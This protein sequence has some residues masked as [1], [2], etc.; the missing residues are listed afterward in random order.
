MAIE[1]MYFTIGQVADHAGLA[2]SV[3]R[4]WET[5]FDVL[6]PAKTEGG[7]RKYSPDDIEIIMQ[8]K[9]LLYEKGF[10]IKGANKQMSAVHG[11]KKSQNSFN[12]APE[13][14]A[15]LKTTEV[16]LA[17]NEGQMDIN[18]AERAGI[19]KRI[20]IIIDQL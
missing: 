10:T 19:V 1:N 9:D 8:I 7:N 3:L 11:I 17:E 12:K 5:V 20:K 13:E 2:Q 4:Y 6:D 14:E 15:P 18:D 16:H